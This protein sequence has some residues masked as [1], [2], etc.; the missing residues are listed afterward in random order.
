MKK[1]LKDRDFAAKRPDYRKWKGTRSR[2]RTKT[3][4]AHGNALFRSL[5]QS[6]ALERS[7]GLGIES[8]GLVAVWILFLPVPRVTAHSVETELGFPF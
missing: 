4:K 6:P 1:F 5:G 8:S 7:S 2:K 3:K